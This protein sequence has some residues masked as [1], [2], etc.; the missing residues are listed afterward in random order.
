MQ[1][2]LA[3]LRKGA[4][5]IKNISHMQDP[6]AMLQCTKAAIQ[7]WKDSLPVEYIPNII[8]IWPESLP[9][10]WTYEEAIKFFIAL[11][12]ALFTDSIPL[13]PIDE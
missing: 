13:R 5:T 11:S 3:N 1:D 12:R 2:T 9:E 10:T 8:E 6:T 7:P 4:D